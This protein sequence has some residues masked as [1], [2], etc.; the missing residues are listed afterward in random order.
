MTS[1]PES[2]RLLM[3]LALLVGG[4][5]LYLWKSDTTQ[6]SRF[7]R[8]MLGVALVV[9]GIALSLTG[10]GIFIGLPLIVYGLWLE[11]RAAFP[12]GA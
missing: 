11:F 10:V 12:K 7:L 1:W 2:W 9:A 4:I 5:A 8:M 6:Y 3:L